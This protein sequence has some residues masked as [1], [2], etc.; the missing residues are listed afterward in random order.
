M[1]HN[2]LFIQVT[3]IAIKQKMDSSSVSIANRIPVA[4][5]RRSQTAK[6]L[7]NC[8][9]LYKNGDR[10]WEIIGISWQNISCFFSVKTKETNM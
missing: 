5:H 4:N 7:V 3:T 2:D 8:T 10:E 9:T 1:W 6:H